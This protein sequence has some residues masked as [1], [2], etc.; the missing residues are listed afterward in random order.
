[1]KYLNEYVILI[2][3]LISS[4]S[5]AQIGIGTITPD[6][7]SNLELKSITQG[8]LPPRMTTGQAAAIKDPATGLIVYNTT[9]NDLITNTGTPSV[10]NWKGSKGGYETVTAPEPTSTSSLIDAPISGMVLNPPAG[11][12]S[13]TF[14]SQFN[15]TLIASSTQKISS[16]LDA[17]YALLKAK[18][19]TNTTH[20]LVFGNS[21][22][23]GE[24]LIPGVY[25]ILGATSVITNLTLDAQGDSNAL[26]IIR[27]VGAFSTAAGTTVILANGASANNVFWVID[28]AVA[29]GVNTIMK[30][31]VIAHNYAIAGASGVNLEGRLLATKGAISYGPAIASIP[32]G[33]SIINLG[34]LAQYVIFSGDGDLSNTALS[35]YTGDIGT[36]KGAIAGFASAYINGNIRTA[37]SYD[38]PGI[39]IDNTNKVAA[40]FSIYQNGVLIPSSIKTL[41]SSPNIANVSLQAIATIAAGQSIEVLWKTGSDKIEMGNRTLTAIKVQ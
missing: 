29:F 15:N 21:A 28:G 5:N 16:D 22:P 3:L 36:I 20:G 32:S 35:Y 18:T 38:T 7:S 4:T 27:V 9:T 34:L 23:A 12:Y 30:G 6:P 39:L 41:S 2:L 37:N 17:L 10:P 26:F 8:F 40:S 14:N 19:P 1:M 33:N 11:T 31:T 25:H 24:V 13:V